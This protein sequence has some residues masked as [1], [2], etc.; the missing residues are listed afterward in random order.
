VAFEGRPIT[1]TRALQRLVASA[2]VDEEIQLIVLRPAGRQTLR[3]RLGAM[4]REIAGERVAAEFGF[5]LRV[6]FEPS[7]PERGEPRVPA[8]AVVAHGSPAER[9]A[10]RWVTSSSRSRSGVSS[11][12][13]TRVGPWA[14]SPWTSPCASP[15]AAG[16]AV[17]R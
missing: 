17:S 14:M 15:S 12:E 8:V 16:S 13:T 3:V 4:P 1:D 11:P 7:T 6:G 2:R 9:P 5:A 10:S